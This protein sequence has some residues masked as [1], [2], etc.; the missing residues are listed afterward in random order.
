M[1]FIYK[2]LPVIALLVSIG[3]L[4]GCKIETTE[5]R[6]DYLFS[7]TTASIEKVSVYPDEDKIVYKFFDDDYMPGGYNYAYPKTSKV[8]VKVGDGA[9]GTNACLEFALDA[10]DYSGGSICLYNMKYD[11]R[12]YYDR[13]ILRF[14]IKGRHGNEIAYASLVDDEASDGKKTVVRK[15]I[16]KYGEI[17]KGE[18]TRIDIP[19]HDYGKRGVYWDEKKRVEVGSRF[20]WEAVT[21]FRIEIKKAQN[22][23]PFTVWVDE[24][25][26]LK[27][28]VEPKKGGEEIYWDEIEEVINGPKDF[29]PESQDNILKVIFQDDLPPGGFVYVYGGKTAYRIQES[30]T[31]GNE[32]V[33][34]A[35]LDDR[36][37]SGVT[38]SLG[39]NNVVDVSPY[40]KKGGIEFWVKGGN[41]GER[42]YIGL[43]DDESDGPEMKVQTKVM[44]Q[45]FV[46]VT[47][48]WK[49]VKI[50]F[51][52]FSNNGKWWNSSKQ[53]EVFG[54]V[55]W[56]RI[57]EI[58]FS[59]NKF[60]NKKVIKEGDPIKLYFDQIQ[61]VKELKGVFDPE[62]FWAKFKSNEPDRL[63][64][65][66][67]DPK[68]NKGWQTP[69]G[70]NS[71]IK[72]EIV[73]PP[74]PPEEAN[75]GNY[76]LKVIYKLH[77]WADCVYNFEENNSP[78]ELRD[79][80]KHWG[81]KFWFYTEKPYEAIT[82]QI[83]DSGHEVFFA[84]TGAIKG[85]HQLLVPFKEFEKFPYWQPDFA[86]QN[87][88]L[89]LDN[90]VSLDFKPANDGTSG[91]YII[92]N[93]Y[94][95]NDRVIKQK[96]VAE[97]M[98]AEITGNY[99]KVVHD[100]I[101]PEIYGINVA[102][103]DGDLLKPQTVYYVQRIKHKVFRYP[104]GLRADDDHWEEVLKKKDWMVDTDEFLDWLKK[105]NGEAMIT[106]NF[107]TGTPEEA[108]RWVEY[109]NIKKKAN[110]KYWEVGNELYGSWHP[111]HCSAEE[112]GK[113]A[114]V[115]IEKMKAVDPTI[116]VTVVWVLEG[117]WNKIVF[118]YTKDIAD[119]VNVHHY[120]Q[121]Y[122]QENDFALLAA[123]TS[124]PAI[125]ED[126]RRQVKEYG[127]PNKKYEVWLTEWNSVDFNPGPQTLTIVQALFVADYLGHLAKTN[128]EI[129]N[130]WDIHNDITP[131]LGD[132]GYLSRTG[133]PDGDNVPRPAYWAF[134]L[135]ANNL[136]GSLREV[137]TNNENLTAYL[138]K[139]NDGST[140]LIVINKS[141]F[142]D[143]ETKLDIE[144][145]PSG[146]A[147]V[148]ELHKTGEFKHDVF[149]VD[150]V[151]IAK[152]GK[153]NIGPGSI[154]TFPK[155][156]VTV[157][158]WGTEKSWTDFFDWNKQSN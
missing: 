54:K 143:Y 95:T 97:K 146:G 111:N 90:V 152:K 62:E 55:D 35:Y 117:E 4:A 37:Y 110:V 30:K 107:G 29:Q 102:L 2:K 38:I 150:Q 25:Q 75:L 67:E 61:F 70:P 40:K 92:D 100:K 129:A 113:R 20:Q 99:N 140:V 105:V 71:D 148:E 46:Q 104:G 51:K 23:A 48:E 157:F 85:W 60:E 16:S 26:I 124:V 156:T 12:P 27:D 13:G 86:K 43:L 134:K 47:K 42:F 9:L 103:W 57:Q 74:N 63:I 24:I 130:Y 116:K 68:M 22:E 158:Q 115:F 14:W 98:Q 153:I 93:V 80:S 84:T 11:L 34:A 147:I 81:L 87:G 18:W 132:Y 118:D 89:D 8:S 125:L 49:L 72:Y 32:A 119:G 122:G 142:T 88:I 149:K 3:V 136:Q 56:T 96:K 139:R 101:N 114:R 5:V 7:K 123:P 144:G 79:W 50:P 45:D 44:S 65:D 10:N 109:C 131:Q 120:P 145:L 28:M 66:F 83:L 151:E 155:Y 128:I 112:Y 36:D 94:L 121:H 77:D 106:V 21:E 33:F 154:Y 39:V 138:A 127:L 64:T 6:N 137:K 78:K 31:P 135:I 76:A 91:W 59:T 141:P 15:L 126:V 108:A 82:V 19:L 41:G 52:R 58:R 53:A 1:K 73:T 133:A 17:K 69:H